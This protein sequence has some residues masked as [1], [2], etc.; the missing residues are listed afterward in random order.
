MAEEN[1]GK[2]EK[3]G[4][5]REEVP[6]AI[7]DKIKELL[8]EGN[9]S[10]EDIAGKFKITQPMVSK[11]AQDL[12][13]DDEI[14]SQFKAQGFDAKRAKRILNGTPGISSKMTNY[15]VDTLVES[16]NYQNPQGVFG[17]LIGFGKLNQQAATVTTNRIFGHVDEVT[18]T[19]TVFSGLF[20]QGQPGGPTA[21]PNPNQQQMGMGATS[22]Q[23]QPI[24]QPQM[25]GTPL[26]EERVAEII[27]KTMKEEREK[28]ELAELRKEVME[29]KLGDGKR[30]SDYI[31]VKEP[32]LNPK[33]GQPIKDGKGEIIMRTKRIPVALASQAEQEDPVET[34]KR[35]MELKKEVLPEEKKGPQTDPAVVA[36]LEKLVEQSKKPDT[37]PET[38]AKLKELEITLETEKVRREVGEEK[39]KLEKDLEIEKMKTELGM[40]PEEKITKT[41]IDEGLGLIKDIKKDVS[42]TKGMARKAVLSAIQ[43][44]GPA[45]GDKDWEKSKDLS[46]EELQKLEKGIDAVATGEAQQPGAPATQEQ[47]P[48]YETMNWPDIKKHA[49]DRGLQTVGKGRTKEAVIAELKELDA[50]QAQVPEPIVP[51]EAPVEE[52]PAG[53]QAPAAEEP[54]PTEQPAETQQPEGPAEPKTENKPA[55]AGE[56]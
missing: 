52:A 56:T 20:Q 46:E 41:V 6:D 16:P 11:L 25:T 55:V 53:P 47:G 35:I 7:R 50:N 45:Q 24:P 5:P 36:L 39:S 28:D 17:L 9:M 18:Q 29:L 10:Q 3:R 21:I 48:D 51:A 33:D 40:S 13:Q 12:K 32:V 54:A 34:L 43:N 26:T 27:G 8:K 37:D 14:E 38:A 49:N 22:F 44:P 31:E 19:N 15:I 42:E 2:E 1:E 30:E 23:P 4:G